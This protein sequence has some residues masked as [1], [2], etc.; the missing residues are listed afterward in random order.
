[1]SKSTCCHHCTE[2]HENCHAECDKYKATKKKDFRPEEVV[3]RDY[4]GER[5]NKIKHKLHRMKKK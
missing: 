1:M 4:Y 3:Y 5:H 2:R